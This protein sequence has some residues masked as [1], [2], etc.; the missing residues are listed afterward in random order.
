MVEMAGIDTFI[1][2]F[3]RGAD[4]LLKWLSHFPGVL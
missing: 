2:G 3:R 1:P 4:Y